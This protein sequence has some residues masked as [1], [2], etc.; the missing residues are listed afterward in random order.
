MDKK[1]K[2]NWLYAFYNQYQLHEE[3]PF[4]LSDE[5]KQAYEEI[6]KDIER[7]SQ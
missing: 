1:K 4:I 2:L 3:Y 5:A 6:K 7:E